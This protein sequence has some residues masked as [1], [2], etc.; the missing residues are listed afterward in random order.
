MASTNT[1][2]ILSTHF[3]TSTF[4]HQRL[5]H[6]WC[7]YNYLQAV[8][9]ASPRQIQNE[10]PQS[11]RKIGTCTSTCCNDHHRARATDLLRRFNEQVYPPSPPL[12]P[13]H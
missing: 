1:T 10:W 11:L 4:F 13:A 12:P 2:T 8:N 6:D 9:T 7:L 3:K 5:P